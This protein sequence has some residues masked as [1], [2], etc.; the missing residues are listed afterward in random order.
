MNAILRQHAELNSNL[1]VQ[2]NFVVQPHLIALVA[3]VKHSRFAIPVQQ[4]HA[5]TAEVKHV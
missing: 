1:A 4:L 2:L 5:A 3:Y